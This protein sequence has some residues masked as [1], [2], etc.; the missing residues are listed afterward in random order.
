MMIENS[1]ASDETLTLDG[2]EGGE[3]FADCGTYLLP[4]TTPAPGWSRQR[5]A[6]PEELRRVTPRSGLGKLPL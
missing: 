2:L 3:R 1:D 4:A 5:L 6:M